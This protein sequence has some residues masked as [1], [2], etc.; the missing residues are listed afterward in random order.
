MEW[1]R[2]ALPEDDWAPRVQPPVPALQS[3]AVLFAP[4]PT[5]SGPE[6]ISYGQEF[7]V[8]VSSAVK[9]VTLIRTGS[10]THSFNF[11]QRFMELSFTT[12][13]P[14]VLKV[15]GPLNSALAP[16]GNYLLFAIDNQDVPSVA[17]IV[18]IAKIS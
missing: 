11:E 16:P 1:Y 5:I 4:R 13:T 6:R 7:E 10:V 17:R 2:R 9:R 8:R 18:Q 14:G 15:Q 3:S 12:S